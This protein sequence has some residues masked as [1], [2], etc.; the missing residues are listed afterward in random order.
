MKS[1]QHLFHMV[2][3]SPWPFFSAIGSFFFVSGLAFY[4]HRI[5]GGFF[6]FL[7]GFFIMLFC[8]FF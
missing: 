1:Q 2:D 8:A 3:R 7:L 5:E 6:V 4:M